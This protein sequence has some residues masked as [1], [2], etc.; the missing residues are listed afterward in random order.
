[1]RIHLYTMVKD[2]VDI[3]EDWL[4]YHGELFGYDNLYV[5]DN[6]ST[7]GTYEILEKY[8]N[9]KKIFLIRESDY[10][11]KGAFMRYYMKIHPEGKNCDIAYPL[12]I[13]EFI[14]FYNREQNIIEPI[15]TLNYI[16]NL[17]K[18]IPL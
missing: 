6:F 3:V 4:I 18:D 13:D 11:K 5:I 15:K 8:R 7:D 10:R 17:P 2:E 14:T 9:D 12:D 16:E 1:M